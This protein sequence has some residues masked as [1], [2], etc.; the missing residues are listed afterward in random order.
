VT[1]MERA[2]WLGKLNKTP[3]LLQS[4]LYLRIITDLLAGL[5]ES[6]VEDITSNVT[7]YTNKTQNDYVAPVDVWDDG[8]PVKKAKKAKKEKT[9]QFDGPDDGNDGENLDEQEVF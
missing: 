7:T 6:V 3:K 1:R 9:N 4:S 2:A 8:L 5:E